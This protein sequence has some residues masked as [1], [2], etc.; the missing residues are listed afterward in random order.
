LTWV[1]CINPFDLPN[2]GFDR[3]I[4]SQN[5]IANICPVCWNKAQIRNQTL[6]PPPSQNTNSWKNHLNKYKPEK[7]SL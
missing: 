4:K 6:V 5:D 1:T 3:G 2:H 7:D